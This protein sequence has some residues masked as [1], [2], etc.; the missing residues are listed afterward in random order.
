M[1]QDCVLTADKR[2]RTTDNGF[3]SAPPCRT[4]KRQTAEGNRSAIQIW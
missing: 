2:Q 1:L 3:A 4:P